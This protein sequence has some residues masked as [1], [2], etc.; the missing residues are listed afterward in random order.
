MGE[1]HTLTKRIGYISY[2]DLKEA[3][4]RLGASFT[5]EEVNE[6]FQESDFNSDGEL[7]LKEFLV[8]LAIGFVLHVRQLVSRIDIISHH[9]LIFTVW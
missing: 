5:S 2:K 1:D 9:V 4:T 8:C 3:L 6:L 7:S